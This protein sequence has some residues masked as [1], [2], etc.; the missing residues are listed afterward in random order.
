[1]GYRSDVVIA[2]EFEEREHLVSFIAFM[3]MNTTPAVQE[4]LDD[5][6]SIPDTNIIALI[7]QGIKWYDTYEYTQAA[8]H[9]Y[10]MAK[11]REASTMCMIV[12]EEYNDITYDAN[13]YPSSTAFSTLDQHFDIVRY[14]KFPTTTIPMLKS[15]TT[16]VE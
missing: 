6:V 2:I 3:R 12:G 16:T 11:E 14:I 1:M 7:Q 15:L 13:C 9:I 4:V 8:E 10:G 5:M